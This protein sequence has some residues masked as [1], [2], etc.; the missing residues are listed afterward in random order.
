MD[1]EKNSANSLESTLKQTKKFFGTP[2]GRCSESYR[3][4]M[5]QCRWLSTRQ[6]LQWKAPTIHANLVLPQVTYHL[7]AESFVSN[8][9]WS[10]PSSSVIA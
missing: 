4:D 7:S 1:F 2:V 3:K 9:A 10:D 5:A 6:I 8:T